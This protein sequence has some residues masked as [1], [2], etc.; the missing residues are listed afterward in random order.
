VEKLWKSGAWCWVF[1]QRLLKLFI[2]RIFEIEHGRRGMWRT[3][4]PTQEQ[5]RYQGK[6]FYENV[7]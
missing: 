7:Q 5:Q 2:L 1:L 3:E 4:L 6:C